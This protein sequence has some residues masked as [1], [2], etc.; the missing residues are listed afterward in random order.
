MSFKLAGLQKTTFIDYPEKIACIVFTQGCNFRCGYCH[1]PEL[2]ENKEP[3]LSVPAFFEFLNKRKGKLDGVVITGGEPTLHGKDLIEFIKEVKLLGFLVKLDTNGTHPDVLQELLNENL[4][5]YIAMDIKAPLAKY[6]T[7]TQTDI[8]TK[9][10]KKSIDMIMN[11]GVDYEFRTTIVR[12][13]LS[14]EDLRQIGELIQG[15]KRYYMQKFLATKILDETLMSEESYT[16]EEF[17]NL[18]TILE[19][20]VDFVDYR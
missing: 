19:E 11:S 6:K 5:D 9:I 16:D 10:I 7:I 14:V 2:F 15:A 4:L 18:R 20:Y 3:V 1:N 8:D 17:K 13:Q 12:S